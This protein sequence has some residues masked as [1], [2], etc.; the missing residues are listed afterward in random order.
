MGELEKK[1]SPRAKEVLARIEITPEDKVRIKGMEKV[2]SMLSDFYQEKLTPED[3]VQ[4]LKTCAPEQR[5][6][7]IKETELK[8]IDSFSLQISASDF[9]KRGKCILAL[10]RA[11]TANKHAQV[12]AEINFLGSLIKK[13]R[14]E[15][16]RVYN[17][18][19]RQV[20]T[21]P[22]LRI[23]QVDTD[24]GQVMIQLAPEEAVLTSAQWKDFI[25]NHDSVYV[26]QFARSLEQLKTLVDEH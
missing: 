5:N 8:L 19:K 1:L 13:Y 7:L 10:E 20:E 2:K 16:D 14:E 6:F 22:R 26:A 9:V 15:K 25:S 11:K 23:R 18:L 4:K 12:K 17:Q 21:N 3:F 24:E